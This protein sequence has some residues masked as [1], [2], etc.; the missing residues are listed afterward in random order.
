MQVSRYYRLKTGALDEVIV[1]GERPLVKAE[2]S[3]L[4][5]MRYAQLTANKLAF[6]VYDAL[7]QLSGRN[8]TKWEVDASRSWKYQYYFERKAYIYELRTACYI[9]KGYASITCRTGG[10]DV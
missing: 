7:K 3:R 1:R 9:I 10:S 6:N 2:G 4:T 5:S 8:G